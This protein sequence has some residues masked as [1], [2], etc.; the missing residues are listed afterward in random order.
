MYNE[1]IPD[2]PEQSCPRVDSAITDIR[3]IEQQINTAH[4]DA[5]SI[6]TEDSDVL[7]SIADLAKDI[8]DIDVSEMED[9]FEYLR[10]QCEDLRAWGQAYKDAYEKLLGEMQTLINNEE[11]R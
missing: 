8:A 2:E 1:T 9:N 5:N 4:D 11:G 6:E 3:S 10:T 7:G